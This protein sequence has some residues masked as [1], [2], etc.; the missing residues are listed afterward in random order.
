MK[1]LL[2]LAILNLSVLIS[3]GQKSVILESFKKNGVDPSILDPKSRDRPDN[4][5][6]DYKY[7]T[8]TGNKESVILAKFDPSK[9]EAEQWTVTSVK[10]KA[11]GNSDIKT[12]RKNHGK[13]PVVG[14]IDESTYKIEKVNADFLIISYKQDPASLP[15]EAKF[16]KDCRLYLTINL[17]T[18]RLEKVQSLNEK[19]LK[20]KIFN[21]EKLDLV[22]KYRYDENEKRYFTESEDLNL[23][24]KFLG[25][26][27][28]METI[29]EYSN[30]KKI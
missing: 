20:I 29:S 15:D 19:P 27:A 10:G 18:K 11:P 4:Y 2:F 14:K 28:P 6:F 13:P 8:I 24:V 17:K 22:A 9:P 7:T 26:L 16:M 1:K 3:F 21:A 12:F 30:Y 23:M 5:T 25:Q